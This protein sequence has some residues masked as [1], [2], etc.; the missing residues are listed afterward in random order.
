MGEWGMGIKKGKG[1]KGKFCGHLLLG[2]LLL[3]VI[4]T[5]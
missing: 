1:T 2:F 3:C 5:Q 4:L